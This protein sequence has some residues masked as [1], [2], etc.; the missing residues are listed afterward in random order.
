MTGVLEQDSVKV[1]S[2]CAEFSCMDLGAVV[3][4]LGVALIA[5]LPRVPGLSADERQRAR[6]HGDSELWKSMPEGPHGRLWRRTSRPQRSKCS[7]N[8]PVTGHSGP[9]VKSCRVV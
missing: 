2:V 5:L 9:A 3:A 7:R 4:S 1:T 8:D 6:L